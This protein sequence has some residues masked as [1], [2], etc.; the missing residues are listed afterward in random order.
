MN[1]DVLVNNHNLEAVLATAIT[2]H[3]ACVKH[4]EDRGL[5]ANGMKLTETS[6]AFLQDIV[7]A[8]ID[9][10]NSVYT[11]VQPTF[12]KFG[13]NCNN[14]YDNADF[15]HITDVK[16]FSFEIDNGA[17]IYSVGETIQ[18]NPN[19]NFDSFLQGIE[20]R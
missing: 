13:Y 1:H 11:L 19:A 4:G 2:G 5:C 17:Y 8:V 20:Y 16:P 9:S 14:H 3:K 15:A 6:R 18:K 12:V 7:E 10:G